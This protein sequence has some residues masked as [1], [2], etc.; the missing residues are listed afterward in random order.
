MVIEVISGDYYIRVLQITGSRHEY[1]HT[2]S[3][4]YSVSDGFRIKVNN[5]YSVKTVKDR[6]YHCNN[7]ANQ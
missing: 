5:F 4:P 3:K 6:S 7:P 1:E 2:A